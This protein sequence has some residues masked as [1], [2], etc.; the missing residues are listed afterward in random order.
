M[1]AVAAIAT[2]VLLGGSG[3]YGKEI[4]GLGFYPPFQTFNARGAFV[5][6]GVSA[7]Y[8]SGVFCCL[9]DLIKRRIFF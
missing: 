4:T 3:V 9:F 1:F 5:R 7:C 8:L 2:V 6:G